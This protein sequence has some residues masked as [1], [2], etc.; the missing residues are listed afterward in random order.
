MSEIK[1]ISI[2]PPRQQRVFDSF[3]AP[4][5]RMPRGERIKRKDKNKKQAVSIT[6]T[7][8]FLDEKDIDRELLSCY[9]YIIHIQ[10]PNNWSLVAKREKFI[11]FLV[12]FWAS[13]PKHC[14]RQIKRG[15][16]GAAVKI[17][18]RSKP[19]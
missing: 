16:D 9:D 17:H 18:R 4:A 6:G 3:C 12:T 2:T 5:K 15:D 8:H 11:V 19:Q 10:S 7:A 14:L 1:K 13:S